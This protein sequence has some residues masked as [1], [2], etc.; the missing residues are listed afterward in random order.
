MTQA[1]NVPGVGVLQFPDGMS[2][3]DM[4]TAI[5][6]N[7]PQIHAPAVPAHKAL[8]DISDDPDVG[9]GDA[10]LHWAS[11]GV[12]GIAGGLS[13]AGSTVENAG[14]WALNK[15]GA[16]L[17]AVDPA[18]NMAQVQNDLTYQPRTPIGAQTVAQ[19]GKMRAA[20]QQMVQAAA[21]KAGAVSPLAGAAVQTAGAAAPM[22]L[23]PV[24]GRV[25]GAAADA[26]PGL[27][28]RAPTPTAEDVLAAQ[29][30][31]SPQSMG[32]ASA[33]PR[34]TNVSPELQQ[35]VVK[36]AQKTGGAINPDVL[37][38]HLE[39][40][41]LP[42]K[43]QLTEGQATQDP[44]LISQEQNTRGSQKALSDH[45]NQQN[46]Q[47]VD[48]VQAIRDQVGPDVFST[49]PVEHADTLIDAYKAKDAAAQSDITAKYQALRDANGGQ[50]PVDA[51]SLLTHAT[52]Q[53]HKDLLFDHAPRSI[54]NTLG[55]LADNGN[56]TF[57]NFE[58]LRSN[59]ARIQRS[60]S[61]DGNEKAAAGVIR[62]AMEQLPLSPGAAQLKPLADAARAAAKSQ[63]DAL[64]ADPAYDAAVNDKVSPDRFV[65]RFVINGAR[66]DVAL[67]RQNLAYNPTAVQTLGVSALDHLRNS[68]RIDP[69]YNGN[70][71]QAGFNKGLQSLG[72]KL[73]AL[74]DPKTAEQL[75]TL[76]NVAR[77]TQFQPRGSFVNNSNTLV[78][79]AADYGAGALEGAANVAAHGIP[80]GTW[81]R[82]GMQSLGAAKTARQS[83]SP[84]AGLDRLTTPSPQYQAMLEAARRKA[85]QQS[86]MQP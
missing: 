30:G 36:A 66:D 65:N 28:R 67:M 80:V 39:A 52:V 51:Q 85:A 76:G 43:V 42:V 20:Y 2:Q 35:A 75:S 4:A 47:L 29:Y 34:L 8:G 27:L 26:I 25:V 68:A 73:N 69:D 84:G 14:R 59:L 56:M 55:R 21:D 82:K 57:E 3:Q 12:A 58:S 77:Y 9:A 23:A 33:A 19:V 50:F 32:A 18:A 60:L 10:L 22:A 7:Y 37:T 44:T 24:V 70:F 61:A 15:F 16:H 6:K 46:K 1:I 54:M 41:S 86:G 11:Q 62:N 72:P 38:R 49:N 17:P 64:R 78:S 13:A 74:V 79:Q 53:L 40:D 83:V 71:S 31:N 5:Q 81:A 45:F 48:N 63:F